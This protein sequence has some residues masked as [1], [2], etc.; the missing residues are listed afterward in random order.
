MKKNKM[1]SILIGSVMWCAS[2]FGI[3]QANESTKFLD[4]EKIK[5]D[6]PIYFDNASP[7]ISTANAISQLYHQSHYSHRSHQSHQSHQSSY[8]YKPGY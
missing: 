1:I 6:S 2:L 7:Q 4:V 5:S 8:P 3:A